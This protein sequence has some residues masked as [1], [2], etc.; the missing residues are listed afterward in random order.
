R[1]LREELAGNLLVR[2]VRGVGLMLAVELRQKAGPTLKALMAEE[3]VL[4]LPAGPNVLRFLPPLTITEEEVEV[5][6]AATARVL[7][8]QEARP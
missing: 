6:V 2:E 3:G 4:A 7:A 1:R 5:G 8:A